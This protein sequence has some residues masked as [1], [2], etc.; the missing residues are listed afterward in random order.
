MITD[1]CLLINDIIGMNA[2]GGMLMT[3]AQKIA[4]LLKDELRPENVRT[5]IE[6]AE[7]LQF[8]ES[9]KRWNE[10]NETA[11]DY[12][13]E[14]EKSRLDEVKTE[15]EF[16]SQDELLKELGISKDEIRDAGKSLKKIS[17]LLNDLDADSLK[18]FDENIRHSKFF[19][20]T[21]Q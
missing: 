9:Q 20:E 13:T 1:N 12:I 11:S 5:V 4:Q 8:K 19:R 18:L 16:I 6:L 10:I 14:A 7:F 21:Q 17:G 15:G 3:L 2:L